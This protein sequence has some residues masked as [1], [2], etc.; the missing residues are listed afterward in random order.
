MKSIF[1]L[2]ILVFNL[3]NCFGQASNKSAI[4]RAVVIASERIDQL[5]K[6]GFK[7]WKTD[8]ST[9]STA[10]K[11][12]THYGGSETIYVEAISITDRD[13][14]LSVDS[15]ISVYIQILN[16]EEKR[17]TKDSL[18][19]KTSLART[20]TGKN[21]ETINIW[22]T[23]FKNPNEWNRS[24]MSYSA[25]LTKQSSTINVVQAPNSE[26]R[27]KWVEDVDVIIVYTRK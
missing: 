4:K 21:N 7:I 23:V 26:D 11:L 2:V 9:N 10:F 13:P 22:E 6:E 12:G 20:Y 14:K 24:V 1:L 17:S 5:E 19:N 27:S 15:Y 25:Y 8:M 16:Q 18:L 3:I